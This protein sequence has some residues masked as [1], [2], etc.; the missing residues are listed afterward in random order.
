MKWRVMIL[1]L[2]LIMATALL[3]YTDMIVVYK[4]GDCTVDVNG[5]GQWSRAALDMLLNV[6]SIIKTGPNGILE[7][8]MDG[9]SVVVT[10]N[11]TVTVRR[12]QEKV[13]AKNK[14]TWFRGL[15]DAFRSMIRGHSPGSDR[16]VLGVRG[17]K[18]EEGDVDWIEDIDTTELMEQY[19]HGIELY[20]RGMWGEAIAIFTGL[21]DNEG[22]ADLKDEVSFYLGSALFNNLQ[23]KEALS[24]LAESIRD[25][26][27]FYREAAL[28]HCSL[29][30]F[31]TG[32][33]GE[34]ARVS[35]LYMNE[36]TNG[37]LAPYALL[38]AG[39]SYK[40]LG[41]KSE[42]KR[43]FNRIVNEYKQAGVYQDAVEELKGM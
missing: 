30:L 18:Q 13:Y 34:S 29:A 6:K 14:I 27:A 33:Y 2:S 39:K 11:T 41:N 20:N 35:T 17:A 3:G 28:I 36:Y 15:T 43:C 1:S 40:G 9:E 19:E 42:A 38:I 37:E 16:M 10:G 25:P 24:Y 32:N 31:L 12:L 26:D 21:V 5:N 8:N 22:M 7:L 4:S 23:Y